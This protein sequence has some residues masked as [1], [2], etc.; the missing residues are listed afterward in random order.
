MFQNSVNICK[1][2]ESVNGLTIV[3]YAHFCCQNCC[4]LALY[5]SY[6]TSGQLFY[7][8]L[9]STFVYHDYLLIKRK[10]KN[11]TLSEKF[12]NPI[13]TYQKDAKS[14]PLTHIHYR[15]LSC[16]DTV[17]LIQSF[18]VKPGS[19]VYIAVGGANIQIVLFFTT[20]ISRRKNR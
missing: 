17:T 6:F 9:F 8:N 14:I 13:R 4:S 11:T 2:I 16:H 5:Q 3:L 15:S 7:F 20:V 18:G 12:Q 19:W 10:T 1:K